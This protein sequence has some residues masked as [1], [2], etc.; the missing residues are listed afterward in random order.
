MMMGYKIIT[1]GDSTMQFNDYTK[2]PQTGWPQAL[3]RF[4]KPEVQ[5]L[6]FARNG[7]STKSFIDQGL[8]QTA[9]TYMSESDLVLI[10]FGHNDSK[11]DPLRHTEAF[12]TY[13]ENL[14]IMV[15]TAKSHKCDVILLTSIAERKFENGHIINTHGQY[16]EAMIEL[17]KELGVPC[18][19]MHKATMNVLDETG[20]EKSKMFFMNYSDDTYN[21]IDG[22]SDDTH[23]RYDGAFMVA[24]CFFKEMLK[25]NLRK[26]LFIIN[27][28]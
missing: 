3:P 2:Y 12:G 15:Q 11:D 7:R 14:K 16:P 18:I 4:L 5:I 1:L 10:E 25:H 17:A 9:S 13:K 23:L 28:A 21:S 20:E 27:E 6:N 24:N 26:E 19:D 22:K 8:L